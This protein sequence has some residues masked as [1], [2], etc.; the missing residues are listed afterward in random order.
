MTTLR[1]YHERT[2]HSPASVH[3]GAYGLDW[4]NQPISFKVYPDLAA[5]P[6]PTD[7]PGSQRFALDAIA[8]IATPPTRALD[9]GL[10]AH[11]LYFSAGVLKRRAYPGGD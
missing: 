1:E 6:L 8:D 2:K 3:A 11:L 10:L 5:F 4:E 7:F 9:I